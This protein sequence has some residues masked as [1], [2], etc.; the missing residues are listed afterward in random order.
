MVNQNPQPEIY[1]TR[2]EFATA[3]VQGSSDTQT[4]YTNQ[5]SNEECRIYA[6][7][8]AVLNNTS[9]KTQG[10]V[11]NTL[12]D[13]KSLSVTAGYSATVTSGTALTGDMQNMYVVPRATAMPFT[14]TNIDTATTLTADYVDA[15]L[16]GQA[17]DIYYQQGGPWADELI[18]VDWDVKIQIGQGNVPS[19]AFNA[20]IITGT[21]TMMITFPTPILVLYN[22]PISVEVTWANSQASPQATTVKC[23]LIAELSLQQV[24]CNDCGLT[25]PYNDGC[26]TPRGGGN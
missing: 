18:G 6:L 11:N 9:G 12:N 22:Q 5:A 25:H 7:A 20:G 15:T 10:F 1:S 26:P 14:A 8:I 19:T 3:Q 16:A 2:H 13:E 24:A 17:S 23:S 4:V 21:D